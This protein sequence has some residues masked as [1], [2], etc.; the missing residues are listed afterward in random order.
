MLRK[1]SSVGEVSAWSHTVS[2]STTGPSFKPHQCHAMLA[3]K[4]LVGAIPK[5][6]LGVHVTHI[7]LHQPQIRFPP[8]ALKRWGDVTRSPKQ[9]YQWPHK[10]DLYPPNIKK[11]DIKT[12]TGSGERSSRAHP[13]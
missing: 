10:K 2:S 3:S 1:H 5:V 11:K 4:R 6:N 8:L 13:N 7:C 9:G 12:K